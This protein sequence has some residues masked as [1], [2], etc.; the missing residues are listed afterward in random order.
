MKYNA[1]MAVKMNQRSDLAAEI[2]E[3]F[4]EHGCIISA[5]MGLH[6]I[7]DGC[8]QDGL[9]TLF[10]DGSEAEINN[11]QNNLNEYDSVKARTLSLN[12]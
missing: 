9:I 3:I 8:R 6:E 2:Q 7:E 4:T 5:R 11:L 10:L 1:I 12:F